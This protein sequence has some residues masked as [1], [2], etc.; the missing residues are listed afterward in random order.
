[1]RRSPKAP[2]DPLTSST[3]GNPDNYPAIADADALIDSI[4]KDPDSFREC[5]ELIRG[6]YSWRHRQSKNAGNHLHVLAVILREI[7]Y[8]GRNRKGIQGLLMAHEEPRLPARE[9]PLA[10]AVNRVWGGEGE[11]KP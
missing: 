7:A 4:I 10:V 11:R 6:M 9:N 8:F 5:R 2:F 3:P 1:M